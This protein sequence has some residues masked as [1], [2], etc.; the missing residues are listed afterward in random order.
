MT[1][2][3]LRIRKTNLNIEK[4]L[5]QIR[6]YAHTNYVLQLKYIESNIINFSDDMKHNE[7][8]LFCSIPQQKVYSDYEQ[9]T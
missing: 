9:N 8:I 4:T 1:L 6:G 5:L 2:N 7:T 3:F